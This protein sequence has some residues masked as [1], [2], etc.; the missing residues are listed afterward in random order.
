MLWAAYAAPHSAPAAG[1]PDGANGGVEQGAP[2]HQRRYAGPTPEGAGE[3]RRVGVAELSRDIDDPDV[4][5]AQQCGRNGMFS[6]M[7]YFNGVQEAVP[8]ML[9]KL[10]K[11]GGPETCPHMAAGWAVAFDTPYQWTK[12]VASDHGGTKGGTGT[13]FVNDKK[14]AEGR[15]ERTQPMIFSADETADVGIDLATTV[16]EAIGSEA[17]SRFTGRIPEVTIEVRDASAKANAAVR[18]AQKEVAR[19]T[20]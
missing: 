20:E 19:R 12:Q 9:K 5:V 1:S 18:E 3:V 2:E 10:D 15:I 14:V 7:T 11:W 8:D 13:L 16:V 6:E 4:G 17:R